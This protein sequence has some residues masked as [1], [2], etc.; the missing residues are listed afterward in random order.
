VHWPGIAAMMIR[1]GLEDSLPRAGRIMRP[2]VT[3]L[4]GSLS[5][6]CLR[7]QDEFHRLPC[8][9]ATDRRGWAAALGIGRRPAGRRE[10]LAERN[11][12]MAQHVCALPD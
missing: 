9:R 11:K 5:A 1:R 12:T 8:S 10:Y 7:P 3:S 6:D 4:R 2:T